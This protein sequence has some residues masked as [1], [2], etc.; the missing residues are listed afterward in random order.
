MA[1]GEGMLHFVNHVS[2]E[3]KMN[4]GKSMVDVEPLIYHCS[5]LVI[6]LGGAAKRPCVLPAVLDSGS[7]IYFIGERVLQ[8]M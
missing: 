7:G 2:V 1:D 5:V 6:V 3:E 4:S 8:H